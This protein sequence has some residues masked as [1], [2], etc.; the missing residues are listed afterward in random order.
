M[1]LLQLSSFP[2]HLTF[3]PRFPSY[4]GK[5]REIHSSHR[6]HKY[7]CLYTQMGWLAKKRESNGPTRLTPDSSSKIVIQKEVL[8]QGIYSSFFFFFKGNRIVH[9]VNDGRGMKIFGI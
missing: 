4:L 7:F 1:Y 5:K 2:F 8:D 6:A 3:K 9:I